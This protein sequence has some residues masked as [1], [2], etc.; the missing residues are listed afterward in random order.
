VVGLYLSPPANAI[1][2]SST[3]SRMCGWPPTRKKKERAEA[4]GLLAVMC[5]AYS[6]GSHGRWPRWVFAGWNLIKSSGLIP[7]TSPGFSSS[8]GAP[9]RSITSLSLASSRRLIPSILYRDHRP[10]AFFLSHQG[11][12][13]AGSLVGE[14]Y[15]YFKPWT[16]SKQ[17]LDPRVGSRCL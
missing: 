6:C 15:R 13:D 16:P 8:V 11:P 14:G 9:D 12:G 17:A 7:L 3:R 4:D 2:L 1:V 5:P 10:V